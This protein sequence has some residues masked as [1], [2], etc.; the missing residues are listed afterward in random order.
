MEMTKSDQQNK[1]PLKDQDLDSNKRFKPSNGDLEVGILFKT[2]NLGAVIGKGGAN[3]NN[4]REESGALVHTS[5]MIQGT[6]ERT[7]KIVG[8]VD[9]VST[10]IKMIIDAVC[11]DNPMISLLAEYKNCG[12][13]IGKQ[14]VTIKKIQEDT[15]A[16][17]HVSKE[18][19]G[20]STQKE[21][22]ISG[23]FDAVSNAID[24]VVMHLAEGNHPTRIAYVP[25]GFGGFPNPG[26]VLSNPAAGAGGWVLPSTA[27][28]GGPFHPGQ[29]ARFGGAGLWGMPMGSGSRGGA[30][31]SVMRMEMTVWVPKE[32]IG[33]IIGRA[34]STIKTVREE[35]TAH[36][37]VHK[38]EDNE[39]SSERKITIKGNRKSIDIACSMLETLVMN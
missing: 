3:I 4:I 29:R 15:G 25:G 36:V 24:A 32:Y 2:Q 1:R 8:S 14:G 20:N 18:C 30:G 22:T 6:P 35:S 39:D 17:I 26:G 21:I 13:V 34:G 23:E 37:Y 5:K 33:K 38:G 7:A 12:M 28:A 16:N 11:R 9:Q 31:A 19:I 27:Q 10:A